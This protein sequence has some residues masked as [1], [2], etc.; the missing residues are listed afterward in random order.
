MGMGKKI[1]FFPFLAIYYN[2]KFR[3]EF[4]IF[5]KE[6]IIESYTAFQERCLQD[7]VTGW[8]KKSL[9]TGI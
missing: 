4:Y 7:Y 8:L 2:P 1:I 6:P 3:F 9:C 5:N